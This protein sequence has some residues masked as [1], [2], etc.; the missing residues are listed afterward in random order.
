MNDEMSMLDS[1]VDSFDDKQVNIV[2][3]EILEDIRLH[4][5]SSLFEEQVYSLEYFFPYYHLVILN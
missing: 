4:L 3:N 5:G 2:M 1:L